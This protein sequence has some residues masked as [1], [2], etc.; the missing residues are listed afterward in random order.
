M[1][2]GQMDSL[3]I[4]ALEKNISAQT[5]RA[6][7]I[8]ADTLQAA[9][10]AILKNG[11]GGVELCFI[12]RSVH[13]L[14]RFSGHMAFPGGTRETN[15]RDILATA[16][17]ETRE[18]IGLD[19]EKNARIAG[20]LDDEMPR[21]APAD[22]TGRSY[23]VTPFVCALT[24]SGAE[25][26]A[27]HDRGEVERVFWMPVDELKKTDGGSSS[28]SSPEFFCREQRIWGMT[29]RIVDNLLKFLP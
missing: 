10:M 13:P 2:G 20:R 19:I 24:A 14:D 15:D 16:V 7:E 9:V 21:P 18:E 29:A 17:R 1:T 3:F 27:T 26:A 12:K 11:R 5:P 22:K 4:D 28:P 6:I 8:P 23:V 25:K